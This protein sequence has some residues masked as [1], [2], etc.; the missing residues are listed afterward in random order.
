M[1]VQDPTRRLMNEY[2]GLALDLA[3]RMSGIKEAMRLSSA[4]FN[5]DTVA[6]VG[7]FAREGLL[8]RGGSVQTLSSNANPQQI[9]DDLA[10]TIARIDGITNKVR[11]G[12]YSHDPL[13]LAGISLRA[14]CAE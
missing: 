1:I 9:A 5:R 4:L 2:R 11:K 13:V 6:A 14:A 12:R 7:D 3:G 10:V 8:Q